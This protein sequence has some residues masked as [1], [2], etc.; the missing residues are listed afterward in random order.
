M[1]RHYELFYSKRGLEFIDE[2]LPGLVEEDNSVIKLENDNTF[3]DND[4]TEDEGNYKISFNLQSKIEPDY[5]YTALKYFREGKEFSF[6]IWQDFYQFISE[7][8]VSKGFAVQFPSRENGCINIETFH[9]QED[10][11]SIKCIW[12]LKKFSSKRFVGIK[13]LREL[14]YLVYKSEANKGMLITTSVL[15]KKA[16]T[17]I[18]DNSLKYGYMD[19]NILENIFKKY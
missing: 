6:L 8:L 19:K 9:Y 15:T 12:L 3:E 13:V 4:I 1:K 5:Y 10:I 18:N 11:G 16:L 7:W 14:E 17:F 2:L